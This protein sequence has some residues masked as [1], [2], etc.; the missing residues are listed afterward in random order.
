MRRPQPSPAPKS[1]RARSEP[2]RGLAA[3]ASR[4]VLRRVS[5]A[6]KTAI[7]HNPANECRRDGYKREECQGIH[8]VVQVLAAADPEFLKGRHS[9]SSST[10]SDAGRANNIVSEKQN[11]YGEERM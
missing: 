10:R 11:L 1:T 9:P 4:A 7:P 2:E 6:L 3:T 5:N 8:F